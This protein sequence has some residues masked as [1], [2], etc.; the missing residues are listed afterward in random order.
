MTPTRT[1][2]NKETG[3]VILANVRWCATFAS[4]LRGFMFKSTLAADEALVLVESRDNRVN[5]SIHMLFVNFDLGV[6]WV[7]SA[8]QIVD[9]IIAKA[10]RLSYVPAHPARYTIECHPSR[11]DEFEIGAFVSFVE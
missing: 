6:V 9:K 10:W 1:I 5:S 4:K 8:G 2:V 11:L 7:N 3:Q